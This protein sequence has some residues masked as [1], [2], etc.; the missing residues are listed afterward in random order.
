V[1]GPRRRRPLRRTL[2]S[3]LAAFVA[4]AVLVVGAAP[5]SAQQTGPAV[6]ATRINVSDFP[7]V[8]LTVALPRRS[9]RRLARERRSRSGRTGSPSMPR[10]P[11]SP[12]RR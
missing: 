1:N 10:S 6:E 9:L 12:T 3:L 7:V 4:L 2:A 5:G 8:R 11:R